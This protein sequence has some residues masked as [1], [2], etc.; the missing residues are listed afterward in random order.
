MQDDKEGDTACLTE[1]AW[2]EYLAGKGKGNKKARE[3][4]KEG[5]TAGIGLGCVCRVLA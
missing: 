1:T 2:G 4:A 3:G 5:V